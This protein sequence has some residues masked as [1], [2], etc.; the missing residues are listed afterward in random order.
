MSEVEMNAWTHTFTYTRCLSGS[1]TVATA[2]TRKDCFLRTEPYYRGDTMH[3]SFVFCASTPVNNVPAAT[4]T[5]VTST[6]TQ[7]AITA[8]TTT[9]TPNSTLPGTTSSPTYSITTASSLPSTD[10]PNSPKTNVAA[11]VIPITL[12]SLLIGAISAFLYLFKRRNRDQEQ[13]TSDTSA[14]S[15]PTPAV[16]R[17]VPYDLSSVAV[18]DENSSPDS[19]RAVFG[20]GDGRRWTNGGHR[21]YGDG[22]PRPPPMVQTGGAGAMEGAPSSPYGPV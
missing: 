7:T 16:V 15:T 1:N 8:T 17:G 11:I 3:S 20:T 21:D 9:T 19:T 6:G 5:I 18:Y 14:K 22:V 10:L 4:T 12:I 2:W 13:D